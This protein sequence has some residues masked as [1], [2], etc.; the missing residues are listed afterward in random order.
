MDDG[1]MSNLGEPW[2]AL[3]RQPGICLL[4]V[5]DVCSCK[6]VEHRVTYTLTVK[7]AEVIDSTQ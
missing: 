7:G 3:C 1:W 5:R 2:R 4:F 6:E